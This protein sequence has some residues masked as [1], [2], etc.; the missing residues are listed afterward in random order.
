MYAFYK[1]SAAFPG[2]GWLAL[3]CGPWRLNLC[4]GDF[5]SQTILCCGDSP[6]HCRRFGGNPGLHPRDARR[7]RSYDRQ[8]M[9]SDVANCLLKGKITPREAP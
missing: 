2:K 8:K 7:P 3:R 1:F 9:S 4:N 5:L 6:V